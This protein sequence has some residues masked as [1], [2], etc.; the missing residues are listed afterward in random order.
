MLVWVHSSLQPRRL[1][2]ETKKAHKHRQPHSLLA[3][4]FSFSY[5]KFQHT[6]LFKGKPTTT[7]LMTHSQSR[8]LYRNIESSKV[9]MHNAQLHPPKWS[10]YKAKVDLNCTWLWCSSAWSSDLSYSLF[11]SEDIGRLQQGLKCSLFC[12]IWRILMGRRRNL[13]I[14]ERKERENARIT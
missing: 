9:H 4:L 1:F 6:F 12:N 2:G 14:D 3:S 7:A 13:R 5:L 8:E 11:I 10:D